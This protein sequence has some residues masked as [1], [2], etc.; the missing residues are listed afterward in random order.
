MKI[1]GVGK[2]S[3]LLAEG[4]QERL[5]KEAESVEDVQEVQ[6]EER[7][8]ELDQSAAELNP[9]QLL[10]SEQSNRTD[11]EKDSDDSERGLTESRLRDQKAQGKNTDL[12]GITQARLEKASTDPYPHRN[13]EA[14]E[15]T[16]ERRQVNNLPEE[17]GDGSDE[18]RLERMEK[19]E[20]KAQ[21]QPDR[22]VDEKPGQQR[23]KKASFNLRRDRGQERFAGAAGYII[24]RASV[25]GTMKPVY[26]RRLAK[27]KAID[28]KLASIMSKGQLSDGDRDEI[29]ALKKEKTALL[30]ISGASARVAA[31]TREQVDDVY[32]L[33]EK[34][35]RGGV[36]QKIL[37]C[38]G[39]E[40]GII[41]YGPANKPGCEVVD[42]VNP[43]K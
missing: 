37:L 42:V 1:Q 26:S 20:K 10:G 2:T 40:A 38:G 12:Q 24:H 32:K 6:L 17:M 9:E 13:P 43:V 25:A 35:A 18:S 4:L 36:P 29:L 23:E 30:A 27:A 14:W 19:H 16:G 15:R 41:D 22:I 31:L 5:S 34:A 21:D 8:G 7:R 3:D 28:E 39:E 33:A 11:T